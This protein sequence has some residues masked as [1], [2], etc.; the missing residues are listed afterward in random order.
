MSNISPAH[1]TCPSGKRKANDD[2]SAPAKKPKIANG[3][4]ATSD[5]FAQSKTIFV[6]RLSW[7]VD[8][9]WLAQEFQECGEV[10]SARV[11]MDRNTGRSRGFAYVAF[12]T[13]EAVEAALKLNGKEIDG[14]PVNIDR[15]AEK[16]QSTRRDARASAFGDKASPPSSTLFLGNL[17]WNTTEDQVWEIFGEYG[18]VK[19]VRLP[20]DRETGKPKGFGYVEFLD[21]ESAKKAFEGGSG[22]EIDGRAVRIDYSQPRDPNSGGRGGGRGGFGGGRGGGGFGGGRGG[23]GDRGGRGGGRVSHFHAFLPIWY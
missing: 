14:R 11:Q 17:S 22:T 18:D 23:F 20:T 9:D 16:D 8:N 15:S 3:D 13:A 10:V 5:E 2:S 4:A 7:N 12:T 1:I 21:I 6:G 19:S